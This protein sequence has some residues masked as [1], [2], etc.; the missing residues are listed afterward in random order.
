[1]MVP[2]PEFILFWPKRKY[3]E[4]WQRIEKLSPRDKALLPVK[5]CQHLLDFIG[6]RFLSDMRLYW[7]SYCAG[8]MV[9]TYLIL[10]TY[11]VIYYTYHDMFS[12]GLKATCVVGVAVPVRRKF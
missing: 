12:T 3:D 11:T 5:A 10:A 2:R 4:F 9:L 7:L 8:L 6:V 1:M